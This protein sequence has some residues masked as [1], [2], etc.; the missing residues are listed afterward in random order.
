MDP[1]LMI[2][3]PQPARSQH[4]SKLVRSWQSTQLARAQQLMHSARKGQGDRMCG[5]GR[6]LAK[7]G[8]SSSLGQQPQ[9]DKTWLMN[10]LETQLIQA[11]SEEDF[12]KAK[13]LRQQL[14]DLGIPS[15][16]PWSELLNSSEWLADRTTQLGYLWPTRVQELGIQGIL[17]R[18]EDTAIVSETGS[19]KTLAYLLPLLGEL[20]QTADPAT[21]VVVVV[22]SRSLGVQVVMLAYQLMGGSINKGIPGNKG[23]MFRYNGP[24]FLRPYGIFDDMTAVAASLFGRVDGCHLIV[25]TPQQLQ[26]AAPA[27]NVDKLR[28]III[29]EA[30]ALLASEDDA[31][32]LD[33]FLA[34]LKEGTNTTESRRPLVA[35][36][37]ATLVRSGV[38]ECI[39]RGWLREPV[40]FASPTGGPA[41]MPSHVVHRVVATPE[42]RRLVAL[43]RLIRKDILERG[44]DES[45]GRTVVFVPTDEEAAEIAP[46]LRAALWQD[47]MIV[48][49][50]PSSDDAQY[51][52]ESFRDN[53]ASLLIATTDTERG[54]DLPNVAH[55]YSL[56]MPR[57]AASYVHRA[58]RAGRIGNEEN[59]SVTTLVNPEEMEPLC[60]L[61]NGLGIAGVVQPEP[62]DVPAV[63]SQRVES[64]DEDK[65]KDAGEEDSAELQRDL[66]EDTYQ[67][68]DLENN[69]GKPEY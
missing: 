48:V 3:L 62:D 53:K 67:L 7:A 59:C 38:D 68:L 22:P 69:T 44:A 63:R 6:P 5:R 49:L 52:I 45:V 8:A 26:L 19:G 34:P 50:K 65:Q 60:D 43:V 47:H 66:L 12:A 42:W 20:D 21:Q 37:G 4:S 1:E 32:A 39:S 33:K 10:Q 25:G 64:E 18:R 58:G 36:S 51:Y 57:N 40:F 11:V 35:V 46:K 29:D 30:D 55:V 9:S 14:D 61:L 56:G 17:Q 41:R 15:P 24:R 31:A 16:R 54:L 27:L 23:N 28:A 13:S 2:A